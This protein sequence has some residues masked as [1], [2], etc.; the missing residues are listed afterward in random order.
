MASDKVFAGRKGDK[1]GG[2]EV[3]GAEFV[4][5][6][7]EAPGRVA[8]VRGGEWEGGKGGDIFMGYILGCHCRGKE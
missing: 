2:E 7:P 5:G 4:R 3:E 6:P 8:W 1:G